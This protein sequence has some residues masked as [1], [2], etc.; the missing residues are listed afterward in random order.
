MRGK[1]VKQLRKKLLNDPMPF[2]LILRNEIGAR[3][4]EL[5]TE[6]VWRNVKRVYKNGKLPKHVTG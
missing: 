5:T 1:K 3:T 2:L 4:E 6:G